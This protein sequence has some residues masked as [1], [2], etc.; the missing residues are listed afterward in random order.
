MLL[1]TTTLISSTT[2]IAAVGT[3]GVGLGAT[4]VIYP[5]SSKQVPLSLTNRGSN[6]R[7]L[8]NAWIDNEANEKTKDFIITPTIFVSEPNSE[9]ALRIIQIKNDLPQDRETV[10]WINAKSIP[11]I[12]KEDLEKSNV[13]QLAIHSRIKL[14]ARPNNLPYPAER[15]PDNIK[16]Y[17]AQNGTKIINNSPYY[18]T[19]AQVKI[20]GKETESKMVAPLSEELF[21]KVKG[22]VISYKT[23]NDYGGLT[24][25]TDFTI[26]NQ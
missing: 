9:N 16:F 15:A 23:V 25:S 12:N 17:T 14:F 1:V 8:I 19:F 10:Y 11:S 4:R 13:L 6:S 26:I 3:G 2:A 7:F 18:I 22:R 21:S 5:I 24:A 20:D